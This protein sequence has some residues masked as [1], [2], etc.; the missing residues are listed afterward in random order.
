MDHHWT[1]R[2]SAG[3]EESKTPAS[4]CTRNSCRSLALLTIG[5]RVVLRDGRRARLRQELRVQQEAGKRCRNERGDTDLQ[6]TAPVQ[7]KHRRFRTGYGFHSS[8]YF[9]RVLIHCAKGERYNV[10]LRSNL[11]RL[12]HRN[13][14]C[15][16]RADE[17]YLRNV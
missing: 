3:W 8:S 16:S 17:D 7:R 9:D 13:D 11:R 5:R 1:A 10:G 14:L 15:K 12:E 4:C 6:Q 2:G